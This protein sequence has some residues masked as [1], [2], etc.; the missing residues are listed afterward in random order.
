MSFL[1]VFDVTNITLCM[2]TWREVINFGS[3]KFRFTHGQ[4]K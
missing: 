4:L 3:Q 2:R 1:S